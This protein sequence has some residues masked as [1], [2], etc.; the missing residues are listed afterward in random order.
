MMNR[1]LF[2]RVKHC[3]GA[4]LELEALGK[5]PLL[6][7]PPVGSTDSQTQGGLLRALSY[8]QFAVTSYLS[9]DV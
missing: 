3:L 4:P 1:V 9:V 8:A 5:L 2:E 7:P 6:P